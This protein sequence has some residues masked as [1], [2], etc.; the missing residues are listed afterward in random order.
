M[1]PRLEDLQRMVSVALYGTDEDQ[2]RAEK[3]KWHQEVM[4][5][6]VESLKGRGHPETDEGQAGR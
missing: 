3:E 1:L 5:Q 6:L 2:A 4:D